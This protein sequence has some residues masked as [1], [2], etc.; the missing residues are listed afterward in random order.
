MP[1]SAQA[2]SS[3][4]ARRTSV[5]VDT[6]L[7]AGEEDEE[8]V[9]CIDRHLATR[10]RGRRRE[11]KGWKPLALEQSDGRNATIFGDS[12]LLE[13]AASTTAAGEMRHKQAGRF[14]RNVTQHDRKRLKRT[15]KLRDL[16]QN[17]FTEVQ[18]MDALTKR[19]VAEQKVARCVCI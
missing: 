16:G 13:F 9:D 2:E 1:I 4:T 14:S 12:V 15:A 10:L 17:S 3:S 7:N 8:E 5:E 18:L 19:I 6:T 11:R